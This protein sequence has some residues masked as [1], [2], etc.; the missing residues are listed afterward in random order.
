[1]FV[2]L[3]IYIICGPVSIVWFLFPLGF[4]FFGSLLLE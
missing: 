3:K 2:N 1:M 4:D